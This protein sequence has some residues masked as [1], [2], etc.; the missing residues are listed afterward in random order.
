M[1]N[2][3]IEFIRAMEGGKSGN[4]LNKMR[5]FERKKQLRDYL[6]MVELNA[7]GGRGEGLL[8]GGGRATMDIPINN[9]LSLL[10][11]IGGSGAYGSV[12]G[13]NG[14]QKIKSFNPEYG[15]GLNIR[16]NFF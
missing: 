7:S 16:G 3:L 2:K 6:S 13:E 10:P 9:Q 15:V 5:D 1:D 8:T 12:P 14:R 11:Y 4:K